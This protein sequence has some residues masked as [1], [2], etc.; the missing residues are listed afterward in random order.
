VI[1]A[2]VEDLG[3]QKREVWQLALV[4]GKGLL[5]GPLCG[6][7]RCLPPLPDTNMFRPVMFWF[8]MGVDIC[9]DARIAQ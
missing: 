3:A 5:V 9:L 8:S 7:H 6:Q 4:W 2:F 1:I